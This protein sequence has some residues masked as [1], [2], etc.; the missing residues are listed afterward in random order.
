MASR[1]PL[2]TADRRRDPDFV[3]SIIADL[4]TL[5]E[6]T[7]GSEVIYRE[8]LDADRAIA[9]TTQAH[10][11]V[12]MARAV[13]LIDG[14]SDGIEMV[15]S[16]RLVM[17][18]GVTAAWLLLTPGSENA[19]LREGAKNRKKAI[20]HLIRVDDEEEE[21][22]DASVRPGLEQAR[23]ILDELDGA[24]GPKS[25]EFEQRCVR[26]AGGG[27]IYVLYRALSAQAHAG[28]GIMDFYIEEDPNSP[29]GI[30]MTP[31]ADN[32]LRVS[33]LAI[34]AAMLFLALN[35]DELARA[36][37]RHMTQLRKVAKK[38]GVPSRIVG[39]DGTELP[40]R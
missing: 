11:A 5:W 16:V 23:K 22:T 33:H 12:R 2:P 32:D 14:V 38:L 40:E 13:L 10:H 4:I 20:E 36:K 37:P 26:L 1:T 8:Q 6:Q 7:M 39:R 31:H 24:D 29:I 17:E 3:R 21:E 18:C 9:I 25:F 19:L 30:S 27:G 34:A 15:P 35:A 28:M